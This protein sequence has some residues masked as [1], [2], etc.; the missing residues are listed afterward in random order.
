MGMVALVVGATGLVGRSVTDELL[1]RGELDEVR[2]LVRRLPEVTHPKL[3]PI[4][5]EWED[6]DRYGDAFPASIACIAVW[7]PR[8][9]KRG[10]SSSSVKWMWTMSSRRLNWPSSTG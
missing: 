5:V 3:L 2:V 9:G 1:G 10:P 7:G 4:L 6:M 8:S